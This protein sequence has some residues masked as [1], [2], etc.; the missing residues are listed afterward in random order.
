MAERNADAPIINRTNM[1]KNLNIQ[2]HH[3][4]DYFGCGKRVEFTG[5][6]NFSTSQQLFGILISSLINDY[7]F[8]TVLATYIHIFGLILRIP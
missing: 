5:I 1:H 2:H 3:N 4:V 6:Y 8:S 7:K